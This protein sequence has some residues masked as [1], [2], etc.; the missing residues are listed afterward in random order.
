MNPLPL[1]SPRLIDRVHQ[2]LTRDGAEVGPV[3][4]DYDH[5]YLREKPA[6]LVIK[7]LQDQGL[8]S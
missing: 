1:N 8:P 4:D 6:N 3:P 7:A 2:A 5:H